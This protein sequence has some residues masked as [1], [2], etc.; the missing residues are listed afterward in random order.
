MHAHSSLGIAQLQHKIKKSFVSVSVWSTILS[1]ICLLLIYTA[2][3]PGVYHSHRIS[4]ISDNFAFKPAQ[5]T[6]LLCTTT[7]I[8]FLFSV[9]IIDQT[10]KRWIQFN[11]FALP[12]SSGLG[13]ILFDIVRART[14]HYL[15]TALFISSILLSH[16]LVAINGRRHDIPPLHSWYWAVSFAAFLFGLLFGVFAVASNGSENNVMQSVAA[17]CEL[18]SFFAIT[19]LNMS[20]GTRAVEHLEHKYAM[21]RR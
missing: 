1:V 3:Y 7:P 2:D 15:F 5:A 20:I 17:A 6:L 13:L 9:C 10:S 21:Q 16:P 19:L 18:I 11:L 14:M 8:W 12:L 4:Y